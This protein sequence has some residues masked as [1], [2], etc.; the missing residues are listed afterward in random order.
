MQ[1]IE[2]G[3]VFHCC[4][5]EEMRTSWIVI[6]T[7][8]STTTPKVFSSRACDLEEFKYLKGVSGQW[9]GLWCEG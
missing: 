5:E 1:A 3:F 2:W 4:E 8:K 9:E 6:H 7:N